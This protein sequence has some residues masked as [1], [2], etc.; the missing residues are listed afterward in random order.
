MIRDAPHAPTAPVCEEKESA[1]L[2]IH[3]IFA[4]S[5]IEAGRISLFS[6]LLSVRSFPGQDTWQSDKGKLLWKR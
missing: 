3:E 5:G 6:V 4:E 2:C 1:Y